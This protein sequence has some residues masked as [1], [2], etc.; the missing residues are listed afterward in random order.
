MM[1][2]MHLIMVTVDKQK[3]TISNPIGENK[4]N[5]K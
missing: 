5:I 2:S 1:F 4:A 3:L